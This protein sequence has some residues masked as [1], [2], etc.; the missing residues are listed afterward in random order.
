MIRI[1]L[2]LVIVFGQSLVAEIIV[3]NIKEFEI[4]HGQGFVI[5]PKF[6]ADGTMLS[7]LAIGTNSTGK[8]IFYL[9]IETE[10]SS[11]VKKRLKSKKVLTAD[12][13]VWSKS[14]SE[15]A[16]FISER[17]GRT[18]F[19]RINVSD[20]LSSSPNSYLENLSPMLGAD[21]L[22]IWSYNTIDYGDSDQILFSYKKKTEESS[23][24]I[25]FLDGDIESV[26]ADDLKN[27][28]KRISTYSDYSFLMF[29]QNGESNVDNIYYIKD[30]DDFSSKSIYRPGNDSVFVIEAG[31]PKN[32]EIEYISILSKKN[33]NDRLSSLYLVDPNFKTSPQ[34]L[35]DSIY[36]MDDNE[37]LLDA[38]HVWVP[39]RNIILYI[40]EINAQN[41]SLFSYSIDQM[42]ETAVLIPGYEGS[43]RHIGISPE[44]DRIVLCD[45]VGTNIIVGDLIFR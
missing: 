38:N 27:P 44:G 33:N 16:Y 15:L 34:F 1:I 11:P 43:L 40:K 24:F 9:D 45:K 7:F 10:K 23:S 19:Y 5:K 4:S 3:E 42:K 32:D 26:I 6:N 14:N 39:D 41:Y 37:Y 31:L 8:T 28:F 21:D 36:V 13:P 25:S 18:F 35:A 30:I 20:F 17:Y 29:L 22:D 2:F 12:L